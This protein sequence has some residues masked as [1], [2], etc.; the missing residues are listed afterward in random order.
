MAGDATE[1]TH[2]IRVDAFGGPEALDWRAVPLPPPGPG[3]VRVRHTAIGINFI[4]T[5]HRSGLYPL[6]LPTGLGGEAAGVVEAL[7]PEVSAWQIGQRVAYLGRQPT[8]A[9]SE[10]RN[11][12]A[13]WLVPLPDAID[14][15]TG[16]SVLLKGLTAWFLLHECHAVAP[17]DVILVHAA[18][19][20]VGQLVT[21]WAASLGA[22]VIGIV[23]S[24]EKAALAEK[25]GCH[26]VLRADPAT[27]AEQVR[28]LTGGAGVRVVYDSVGK[29]TFFA[30]LDCLAPRGLMV[31]YGN[32]SGAVPPVAPLELAQRGSLVLTRPVLF[33]FIA[34]PEV[35]RAAVALLFERI[36]DGTLSVRVGQRFALA[37]AADAHRALESRATI[38]A[39]VLV[40]EA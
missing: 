26:H 15:D 28:A 9:Y 33:D 16:A 25:N 5:Y 20:G 6:T 39:T 4:D 27:Q 23:S 7:G 21:Q 22:E 11:V 10:R 19:G 13:E 1:T 30:S 37:D 17:G 32:A 14:D 40:P 29:D 12:P 31:T 34:D 35:R 18:S 24:D 2:A 3:E 8:D 36:A 38:G